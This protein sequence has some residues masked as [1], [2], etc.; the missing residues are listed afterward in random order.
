MYVLKLLLFI[1]EKKERPSDKERAKKRDPVWM[2]VRG[3]VVKWRISMQSLTIHSRRCDAIGCDAIQPP[4][5][6]C[7]INLS[8]AEKC[9]HPTHSIIK[10]TGLHSKHVSNTLSNIKRLSLMLFVPEWA[11]RNSPYYWIALQNDVW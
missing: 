11:K 7:N 8:N 3:A 2:Y 5:A 10:L 6:R 9:S 1:P 4:A